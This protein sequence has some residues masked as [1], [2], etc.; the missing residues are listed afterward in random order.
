MRV[1]TILVTVLALGWVTVSQAAD[2]STELASVLQGRLDKTYGP[3]WATRNSDAFVDEFFTAD[4]VVTASDGPTVW[5]GRARAL[6]VV[7]ELMKSYPLISAHAVLTRRLGP[8]AAYQF[9]VF[10][11]TGKDAAGK[12]VQSTAKSLYIWRK[13]PHGWRVDADHYSFAGMDLP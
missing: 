12:S 9:V 10:T 4:P 8:E 1:T 11:L 3:I 2:E 13:G 6:E 5:K 7:R